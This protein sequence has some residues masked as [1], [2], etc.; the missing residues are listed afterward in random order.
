[1]QRVFVWRLFLLCVLFPI[2]DTQKTWS[3]HHLHR[4]VLW[5]LPIQ[6]LEA[7]FQSEKTTKIA[8]WPC[9]NKFMFTCSL[10]KAG[11]IKTPDGS[12]PGYSTAPE[13]PIALCWPRDRTRH[14][15]AV[16][17]LLR[18]TCVTLLVTLH[19]NKQR[20]CLI[21]LFKFAYRLKGRGGT[22]DTPVISLPALSQCFAASGVTDVTWGSV[23]DVTKTSD[24]DRGMPL[25]S[26]VD[27]CNSVW[28]HWSVGTSCWQ[29]LDVAPVQLSEDV[30]GS[31]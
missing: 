24:R 18:G 12:R 26:A 28:F 5:C 20:I 19:S 27:Q 14:P 30:W 21:T 13:K 17:R 1:M 9:K 23:S 22:L 31:V 10:T 29:A 15:A 11:L 4:W 3:L 16:S 25:C 8:R 6:H 2:S 7:I